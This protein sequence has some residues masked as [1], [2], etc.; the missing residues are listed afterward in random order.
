MK[1]TVILAVVV[2]FFMSCDTQKQMK[3]A[4]MTTNEDSLSYAFGISIGEN[5]K[6]DS[7]KLNP[8][9][10]G[11]ALTEFNEGTAVMNSEEANKKIQSFFEGKEKAKHQAAIG[12]GEDF[13]KENAAN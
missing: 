5:L 9:I 13:L 8:I 1:K 6:R 7:I 10:V 11:K 2:L 3:K 12:A 4:E